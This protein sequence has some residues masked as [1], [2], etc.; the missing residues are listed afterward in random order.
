MDEVVNAYTAQHVRTQREI[1]DEMKKNNALMGTLVSAYVAVQVNEIHAKCAARKGKAVPDY[2]P[3][4]LKT[5]EGVIEALEKMVE[6]QPKE[7]G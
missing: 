6:D 5:L 3:L 2:E 4:V 1:L 7:N